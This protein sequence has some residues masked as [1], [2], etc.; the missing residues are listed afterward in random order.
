MK[1][2]SFAIII[3]LLTSLEAIAEYNACH[4][5]FIIE[6]KDG[7]EIKA[8]TYIAS[9]YIN[10][11]ELSVETYLEENP[12]SLLQNRSISYDGETKY[13]ANRLEYT[14]TRSDLSTSKMLK[15]I[16]PKTL[17]YNSINCIGNY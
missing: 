15:V 6:L 10:N 7:S 1:L 3:L 5:E 8:Y 9:T 17:D 12:K 14:Y 16:D 4:I 13:F 11:N 2:R